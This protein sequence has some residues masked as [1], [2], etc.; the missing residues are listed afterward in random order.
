ALAKAR[1]QTRDPV[2][3]NRSLILALALQFGDSRFRMLLSEIETT[4]LKASG[5]DNE[6][7]TV[8]NRHDWV[9]HMTTSAGLQ[10][11][12][13]SGISDFIGVAKEIKDAQEIEGFSFGDLSADRTGVRL[14]EVA[15]ASKSSARK[16]QDALSI[17]VTES[18]FFPNN[19]GLP[20]D[21]K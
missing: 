17:T 5:V 2:E 7:V 14:A 21:L 3:E 6:D 10:V 20:E 1:S 19:H 9:Q 18:Q 11:A 8:Q 4:Q 15:T 16:V 12:A 13:N